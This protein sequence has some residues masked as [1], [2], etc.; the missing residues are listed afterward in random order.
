[1]EE[2]KTA[3]YLRLSRED[4]DKAE[5]D[6]IGSQRA[7]I[8][9]YIKNNPGLTLTGEYADDGYSGTSY[10]RPGFMRM[11]DD[12]WRKRINCVIVKDLSRLGRDYIETGRYIEKVFPSLEVRFIA[13]NDGYDSEDISD[14]T[15]Q[16]IIPFKN[17][18]ND[19]YCRDIS[20]KVRSQ[21]DVKRK[22]GQFIG[23]FAPYGYRK[24][25][26]DSGRLIVDDYAA[27]VVRQ[28]F[29]MKLDG[30]SQQRIANVLNDWGV[31]CPAEYKRRNGI[32]CYG[33]CASS[34]PRWSGGTVTRVLENEQYIGT[35]VQGKRRKV[36]YK[37][38]KNRDVPKEEWIR[39]DGTHEAVIPRGVFEDVQR[40]LAMDTRTSPKKETVYV[41]SGIVACGGCGGSMIRRISGT[42]EKR[43]YYLTCGTHRSTGGCSSHLI[44]TSKL[45]KLVLEGIREQIN[46]L[47]DA[48]KLI[49]CMDSEPLKRRR[50]ESL[51]R[52][53]AELNAESTR[54]M[55]LKTQAY[56]DLKD[57]LISKE[58]Y[59]ELSARFSEGMKEAEEKM[60]AVLARK[61][62]IARESK[63]QRPW[64]EELRRHREIRSLD[65]HILTSLVDK[66]V[67]H[68]KDEIEVRFRYADEMREMLEIAQLCESEGIEEVT[69]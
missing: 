5:S 59:M 60:E 43:L 50:M 8:A 22:N 51:D 29:Q 3:A 63:T 24:S 56:L 1:M 30:Y 35:M 46:L 40:L 4:G 48:E 10:D 42:P 37:V 45:E 41:F 28:I 69:A 66:I 36:N 21:L 53:A 17:L 44:N 27:G 54:C 65:R 62:E 39:V 32:Q 68:S 11:M 34:S 57:G 2:Y 52:R 49:E 7:L 58:E 26:E 12:I 6:S 14:S 64:M 15:S 16:I 18:V 19:A 9:Q 23:S 55:G 61:Q 67:V 20:I 13:I 31:L 33:F 25:P 47:I 38:K